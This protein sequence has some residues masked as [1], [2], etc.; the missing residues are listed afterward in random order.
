MVLPVQR[1]VTKPEI[2]PRL[3]KTVESADQMAVIKSAGI[4][5]A[6]GLPYD[7]SACEKYGGCPY[8][9]KCGLSARERMQSIM[10]QGQTG[11]FVAKLRK[12]KEQQ[13]ASAA[14]SD[15]ADASKASTG[16]GDEEKADA[17]PTDVNP[18]EQNKEPPK[19][20]SASVDK[21]A[22]AETETAK[23]SDASKEGSSRGR[24]RPRGSKNRDKGT[25]TAASSS[26]NGAGWTLYI[27]CAPLRL[28][29][30]A[31][32]P[33]K[34]AAVMNMKSVEEVRQRLR[35]DPPASGVLIGSGVGNEYLF[36]FAQEAESI[37]QG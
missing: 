32:A 4:K 8:Q 37:I 26:S 6:K 28:P 7:A 3:L 11:D 27:D 36:A 20:R 2:E 18:P 1:V 34:A 21:K 9:D 12:Q 16:K 10:A 5:T 13:A 17:A 30:D 24:G 35:D 31:E 29:A 22:E 14:P 25:G 23:T 15:A 33:I 19:E